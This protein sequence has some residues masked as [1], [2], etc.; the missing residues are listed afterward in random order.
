MCIRDRFPAYP[1]PF[2]PVT[3]IS[4]VIQKDGF[5]NVSI[6]DMMGRIVKTLVNSQQS[7][8]NK[9]LSWNATDS[10]NRL[11]PAGVYLYK[12]EFGEFVSTRKMILLK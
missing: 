5:V 9:F 7:H 12:I 2:N 6:Y 11:V 10:R 8:G 1:N 4:Y 3:T